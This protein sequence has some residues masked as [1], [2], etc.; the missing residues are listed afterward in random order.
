MQ[1]DIRNLKLSGATKSQAAAFDQIMGEY[2]AYRLSTFPNLKELCNAAP[3][4]AM[5][6]LFKGYLLLSMGTSKVAAAAR[7]C[8]TQVNSRRE[9]L[10]ARERL[11]LQALESWLG[12]DTHKAS[13]YWQ[14]ILADYPHDL[15][16]IKLHHFALFWLGDFARMREVAEQVLPSWN[17][18]TPDYACLLGIYAFALEETGEYEKA[19][20]LG[21]AAAE[22]APD[23]LWALHAVAHVFEMQGRLVDGNNWF[24]K[25][26]N[27]WDDR[28]PFRGHMWWHAALF[29]LEA[30]QFDRALE[31]YDLAVRPTESVFYL[32]IQNTASLLARFEFAGIN[33]GR[34]WPELLAA[35]ETRIGDHGQLFTEPHWAMVLSRANKF[36]TFALQ[37]ESLRAFA[38]TPNNSVGNLVKPIVLPLCN[39]IHDF[40]RKNYTA[41]IAA[42]TK[43]QQSLAALGGS[44]A[45]RDIFTLYLIESAVRDNNLALAR[46]LLS[47]RITTRQNSI[48]TWQKYA[49]ICAKLGDTTAATQARQQI[50]RITKM[51]N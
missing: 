8:L 27:F 50:T 22:Q 33:C 5:A 29:A 16:A 14:A 30:G 40:H 20:K 21:R 6:H 26:L 48:P 28:N 25:P 7:E 47:A 18:S 32:D 49:D 13:D 9:L 17:E 24:N 1:T 51:V 19:E 11:H 2:I 41:A 46:E 34:R 42:L 45:Q 44:S 39:A 3:D 12:G 36:D 35:V 38:D 43:L 31:L 37:I 4:F 15:L 23:D 10:T